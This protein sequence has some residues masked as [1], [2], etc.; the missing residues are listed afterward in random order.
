MDGLAPGSVSLGSVQTNIVMVNPEPVGVSARG[1]VDYLAQRGIRCLA[2]DRR[3]VR[4]VTHKDVTSSDID[5]TIE[6]I[7]ALVKIR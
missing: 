5:R 3:T 2:M 7:E 4:F 1:L 6:I